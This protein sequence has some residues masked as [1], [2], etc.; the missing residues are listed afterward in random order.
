M[1]FQRLPGPRVLPAGEYEA[2]IR[3]ITTVR[4]D[5][6]RLD[7]EVTAW[8]TGAHGGFRLHD[9]L[10]FDRVGS[11]ALQN[12]AHAE[13]VLAAV[14]ID[15]EHETEVNAE[16]LHSK[17]VTIGVLLHESVDEDGGRRRWNTIA[18]G[19]YREAPEPLL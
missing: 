9:V 15:T 1:K 12:W 18:Y 14:G 16:M 4:E 11:V 2:V 3:L 10:I 17:C 6:W 5:R 19:S 7:L 8:P 13:S